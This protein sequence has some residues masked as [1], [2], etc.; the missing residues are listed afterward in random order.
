M[1]VFIGAGALLIGLLGIMSLADSA[2]V[3]VLHIIGK[4]AR[5]TVTWASDPV[6]FLL[7][8]IVIGV[9]LLIAV[10]F[11]FFSIIAAFVPR[12]PARQPNRNTQIG[13]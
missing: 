6:R 3:G 8:S 4:R 7:W 12:L 2:S 11:G 5:E 1:L 10:V 13:F 9:G